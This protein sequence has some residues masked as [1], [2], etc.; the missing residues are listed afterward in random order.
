MHPVH[1][2]QEQTINHILVIYIKGCWFGDFP[3]HDSSTSLWG[4]L[5]QVTPGTCLSVDLFS[6]ENV[7]VGVNHKFQKMVSF[8][9]YIDMKGHIFFFHMPFVPLKSVIWFQRY[10]QF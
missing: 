10:G 7:K 3:I 5:Y 9:T 1:M 6:C 2:V 4:L 8:W